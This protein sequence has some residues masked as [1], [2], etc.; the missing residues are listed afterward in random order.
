MSKR[1]ENAMYEARETINKQHPTETPQPWNKFEKTS[2]NGFKS[3]KKGEQTYDT[4]SLES[5]PVME[6]G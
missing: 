1:K 3:P 2:K 4:F 5:V 6:K